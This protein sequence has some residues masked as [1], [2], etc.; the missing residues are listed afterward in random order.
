MKAPVRLVLFTQTLGC[1]TCPPTR[2]MLSELVSL[3]DQLTLEE[4]NLVLDAEQAREYRVDRA[5]AIAVRRHRGFGDSLHRYA[6]WLRARVAP[7]RDP[8][9]LLGRVR[10]LTGES[11]VG[12]SGR[13]ASCY[14]GVCDPD[15]TP[16]SPG[17][18]PGPTNGAREPKD[19][20][21]GRGRHRVSR[22][23]SGATASTASPRPSSTTGWRFSGPNP[24]RSSSAKSSLCRRRRCAT[25]S[26]RSCS[27]WRLSCRPSRFRRHRSRARPRPASLP[28]GIS[29]RFPN[30]S[31][32]GCRSRVLFPQVGT[33]P[34]AVRM[35]RSSPG[36]YALHEFAKNVY[37]VHAV[38]GAGNKL[39]ITRPDAH[40][41]DVRGH[42]GT[43]RFVYKVYGDRVDGTYLGIDSTHAHINMPAALV[44]ARGLE[45]RPAQVRFE[46]PTGSMWQ[47]ATQLYPSDDP[48]GV[49]GAEPTVPVGQPGGVQLILAADLHGRRSVSCGRGSDLSFGGASRW[50]GGSA[51]PLRG[52]CRDHRP[53]VGRH[54]RRVSRVRARYVYLHR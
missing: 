52:G 33:A 46:R 6:R 40:Q 29:S 20:C 4:L 44:W 38:D 49:Y 34:L 54:L 13:R 26:A 8:A 25:R 50:I 47:V 24:R 9:G 21:V 53:R 36:R 10:P 45:G 42:D 32:D 16:L 51:R 27:S 41:W 22:F 15:L 39:T 11:G 14:T 23:S 31:I 43:V 7:R 28:Y 19:L 5:P 18:Q 2:Q 30:L 17:G 35:S 3:S 1:E 37:D 48:L 12:G